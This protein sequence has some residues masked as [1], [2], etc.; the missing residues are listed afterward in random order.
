MSGPRWLN[1]ASK[2]AYLCVVSYHIETGFGHVTCSGQIAG[3]KQGL[4]KILQVCFLDQYSWNLE[5]IILWGSLYGQPTGYWTYAGYM[6]EK[7]E[8][9]FTSTANNPH[10]S[11]HSSYPT[12]WQL[13]YSMW[14]QLKTLTFV[15]HNCMQIK[16]HLNIWVLEWFIR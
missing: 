14:F 1:L 2:H 4:V 11:S 12:M 6:E 7:L 8:R 13:Q 9:E 3:S 15:E 5:T 16:Y 10:T